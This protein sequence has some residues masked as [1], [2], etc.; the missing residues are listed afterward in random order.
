MSSFT[1][2]DN[3]GV[4]KQLVKM[5]TIVAIFVYMFAFRPKPSF[6]GKIFFQ[7]NNIDIKRKT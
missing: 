5:F 4:S 7:F 2:V 3:S 1:Q 6:K